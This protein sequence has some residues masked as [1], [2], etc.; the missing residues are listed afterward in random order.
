[1]KD[2]ASQADESAKDM[3]IRVRIAGDLL[4]RMEEVMADTGITTKSSFV[5]KAIINEI[6]RDKR[7][8][9]LGAFRPQRL[10]GAGALCPPS[11]GGERV[12]PPGRDLLWG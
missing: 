7:Q 11:G 5:R 3:V 2:S 1:M 4:Q 6:E 10:F 9:Q 12:L 8:A